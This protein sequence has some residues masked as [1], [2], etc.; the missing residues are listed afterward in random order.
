MKRFGKLIILSFL[1]FLFLWGIAEYL[2]GV[3]DTEYTHKYR[4]VRNN[5]SISTLLIG[6]SLFENSINPHLIQDDSIYDFATSGRWIYWDMKLA[7]KLFP[8]MPNLQTVIFPMAYDAMYDSP[9]YH[10][11]TSD[12]E[13]NIFRY[14]IKYISIFSQINIC[15][16]F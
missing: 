13:Y 1:L 15:K 4:Q 2:V 12:E 6:S 8:T 9:H 11:L 5:S 16:I 3:I 10:D 7:E 14:S